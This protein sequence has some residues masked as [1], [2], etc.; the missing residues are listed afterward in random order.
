MAEGFLGESCGFAGFARLVPKVVRGSSRI[1]LGHSSAPSTCLTGTSIGNLSGCPGWLDDRS[2]HRAGPDACGFGRRECCS[3]S[4]SRAAVVRA[5][6][7]WRARTLVGLE[8]AAARERAQ[9]ERERPAEEEKKARAEA[10]V[11]QIGPC[12]RVDRALASMTGSIGAATKPGAGSE[13][14]EQASSDVETLRGNLAELVPLTSVEQ[15][16]KLEES[17][18]F[19]LKVGTIA[20]ALK[21]KDLSLAQDELSGYRA[22]WWISA[23]TSR[24]RADGA[25]RS[26]R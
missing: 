20:E 4:R 23:N 8:T 3:L 18:R 2:R 21:T 10:I 6:P 24:R 13:T 5:A 26:E 19:L 17:R 1:G 9:H 14:Y 22:G 15:R 7:A 25:R 11:K 16:V 12:E